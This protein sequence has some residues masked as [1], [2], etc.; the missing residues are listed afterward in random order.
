MAEIPVPFTGQE[1]DTSEDAGNIVMT[2]GAMLVGFIILAFMQAVGSTGAQS[3]ASTLGSA[4]GFNPA[5]GES[6]DGGLGVL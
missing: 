5:T 1:I 2:L 4:L 3:L 6:D